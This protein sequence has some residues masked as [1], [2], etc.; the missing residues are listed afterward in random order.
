MTSEK[1]GVFSIQE[2]KS[3][4]SRRHRR[5]KASELFMLKSLCSQ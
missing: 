2:G 4:R 5:Q 3:S 1:L